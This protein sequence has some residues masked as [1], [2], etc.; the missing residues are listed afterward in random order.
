MRDIKAGQTF[1]HHTNSQLKAQ[2][3]VTLG[4]ATAAVIKL[5]ANTSTT[6][7]LMLS[8]DVGGV[9]GAIQVMVTTT[10]A[11]YATGYDYA[12]RMTSG[13]IDSESIIGKYIAEFS[14]EN[15]NNK[16]D[17]V[18]VSGDNVAAD[19]LEAM[20]DG[21]GYIDSNAPA[22]QAQV[23]DI[24]VTGS[25]LIAVAASATVTQGTETGTYANTQLANRT[26]H[27]IAAVN[28]GVNPWN[29]DYY[30]EFSVGTEGV[31]VE[32]SVLG[33]LA[34]GAAPYGGDS[35]DTYAYNWGGSSWDHIS[36]AT[37]DFIGSN[38]TTDVVKVMSL[39]TSHVGT[40]ADVGKVRIRLA[41]N[42]LESGTTLYIDQ[43]LLRYAIPL[44]IAGIK[45]GLEVAGGSIA[46]I[47]T[48][49]GTTLPLQLSNSYASLYS[50]ILTLRAQVATATNL[51][52]L[53]AVVNAL[54]TVVA[55][56]VAQMDART[57]PS[58]LYATHTDTNDIDSA[59]AALP[60]ITYTQ[61]VDRTLPSVQY[62]T[63]T[64][65]DALTVSVS[66]IPT[67]ATGLTTSQDALLTAIDAQTGQMVFVDNKI[68]ANAALVVTSTDISNIAIQT[69]AA[70][71]ASL[72]GATVTITS[73][74]S[75]SGDITIIRGVD[76][77]TELL[78]NYTYS[79]TLTGYTA[80]MNSLGAGITNKV[81]TIGGSAGA[82][83]LTTAFTKAQSAAL[84]ACLDDYSITFTKTA[85]STVLGYGVEGNITV[86]DWAGI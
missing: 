73:P 74:V 63:N 15:A 55:P 5:G 37:G 7:G 22:Y 64:D 16:A 83:T 67:V 69:A 31:P 56:T 26:Y 49:T 86:R 54:P 53:Q 77:T 42:T 13:T 40:G 4:V 39:T 61:L 29:I 41:G 62:A 85:D 79:G 32:L 36:P 35:V 23:R 45:A 72:G 6:T 11:W 66:A 60:T 76:Y 34:E 18:W 28:A 30:Y 70:V 71:V 50:D 81:V 43:I 75:Q 59:I 38:S 17:I 24:A 27:Q 46:E 33:R 47:L 9:V 65:V 48:D 82:W 14:I 78:W 10:D 1:I 51:T 25:A 84:T 8:T 19:N 57:I 68:N 80:K 2:T 12:V 52:A 20:F 44:T 21:T 58:A 3:P